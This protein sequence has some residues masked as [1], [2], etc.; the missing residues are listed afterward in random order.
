MTE[1][2]VWAPSAT[3]VDATVRGRTIAM[4][5]AERG[6][7]RTDTTLE[8]GDDYGFSLDGGEARPDPRSPWQPD[9]V[10]GPSRHVDHNRFVWTDA[11]WRAP[12][13]GS[14]IFYELHVGTFTPEGTFEAAID[15]LDHLAALGITAIELMPVNEFAG[16][17]GWGYDGVDLYAPHQTYGGPDGLK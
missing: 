3:T 4:K 16:E 1:L 7:W 6:W 5:R 14:A 2:S 11:H 9:G 10:H 8:H 13:L 15:R 17:R 12:P